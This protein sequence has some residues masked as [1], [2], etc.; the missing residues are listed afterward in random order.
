MVNDQPNRYSQDSY[1]YY[2]IQYIT[3]NDNLYI[4]QAFKTTRGYG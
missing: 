3:I 4:V 2:S 1:N